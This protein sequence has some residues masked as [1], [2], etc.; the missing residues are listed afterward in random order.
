MTSAAAVRTENTDDGPNLD[1][2]HCSRAVSSRACGVCVGGADDT[3]SEGDD[4]E[5]ELRTD[6]DTAWRFAAKALSL[7]EELP[8]FALPPI[9]PNVD[10]WLV[11]DFH[12]RP[13]PLA[14]PPPVPNEPLGC[15]PSPPSLSSSPP[16]P[17][18]LPPPSLSAPARPTISIG[19]VAVDGLSFWS[20]NAN[21][22][23][24]MFSCESSTSTLEEGGR[25]TADRAA[26]DALEPRSSNIFNAAFPLPNERLMIESST[27]ATASAGARRVDGGDSAKSGERK[28]GRSGTVSATSDPPLAMF[29]D[30]SALGIGRF[31][32]LLNAAGDSDRPSSRKS[33][34]G[35]VDRAGDNG[36]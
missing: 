32:A 10:H 24:S 31:G 34:A 2:F 17:R 35:E 16:P 36:A 8:C 1:S 6:G 7:G 13:L 9:P 20:G 14:L 23:D 27:E 4:A 19:R 29:A 30:E 3:D 5:V 15:S 18:L 21:A 12:D 25:V 33:D 22:S 11:R 28:L 26:A